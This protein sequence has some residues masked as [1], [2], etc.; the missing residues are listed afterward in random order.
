M[1]PS[2]ETLEKY[3]KD[4]TQQLNA[5]GDTVTVNAVRRHA[6]EE[7]G[8]EKGFFVTQDWKARS[9]ALIKDFHVSTTSSTVAYHSIDQYTCRPPS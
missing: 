7:N 9:S 6:E 8:L 4:A 1:A 5:A 2:V 3:L